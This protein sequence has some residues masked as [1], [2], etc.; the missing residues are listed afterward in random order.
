MA[1]TLA[2]D[3]A[4][5]VEWRL[6]A[7][8][9]DQLRELLD[10]DSL[11]EFN[12]ISTPQDGSHNHACWTQ[13][14]N[15]GAAT[16]GDP[17]RTFVFL[18][19]HGLLRDDMVGTVE[20]V[21]EWCRDNLEHYEETQFDYWQY[22]G[23]PPV[24]RIIAGTAV[25][26]PG[27]DYDGRFRHWTAGCAGTCG[28]LKMVLRTANIP[29][30]VEYRCGPGQALGHALPC[31][32]L[33]QSDGGYQYLSHGDDPYDPWIKQCR[34]PVGSMR[35]LLI[36]KS[37]FLEWF[38]S[39]H[40]GCPDGPGGNISRHPLD[41]AIVHLPDPLLLRRCLD[42][43]DPRT[44][45]EPGFPHSEGSEVFLGLNPSRDP[46]VPNGREGGPMWFGL[47]ELD[48]RNL[49]IKLDNKLR[50]LGGCRAFDQ[51]NRGWSGP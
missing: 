29:V 49:W 1:Q 45:S 41:L 15:N 14:L 13:N 28:F 20:R 38:G 17:L 21:L 32:M 35:E 48:R 22:P 42:L 34:P 16:P 3:I 27:R 47:E 6:S 25:H 5:R 46:R 30:K 36:D 43:N 39:S 24:E 10:S 31:F 2:A 40:N 19:D 7:L 50:L 23:Q 18:R 9:Q 11:F 44:I 4:G 26:A 8:S 37:R 12:F 51:N 33:P